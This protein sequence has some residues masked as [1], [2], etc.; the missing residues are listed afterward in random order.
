MESHIK[1]RIIDLQQEIINTQNEEIDNFITVKNKML[2]DF[3]NLP[4][5]NE[6]YEN[7]LREKN[8]FTQI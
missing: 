5:G 7:T 3:N 4:T 8:R 1:T 6:L 2:A